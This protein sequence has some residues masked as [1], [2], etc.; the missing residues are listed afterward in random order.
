MDERFL[1]MVQGIAV[2]SILMESL[3]GCGTEN[4]VEWVVFLDATGRAVGNSGGVVYVL[5]LGRHV[6]GK[7]VL[8]MLLGRAVEAEF[9]EIASDSNF[10]RL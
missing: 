2:Y 4:L 3:Y 6:G 10:I 8:L 9:D 1:W 5:G 7:T